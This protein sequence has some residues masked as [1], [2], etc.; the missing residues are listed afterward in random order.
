MAAAE[1]EAGNGGKKGGAIGMIV[2][3]VGVTVLAAG[4]GG[5]VAWLLL[6]VVKRAIEAQAKDEA[7]A[8]TEALAYSEKSTVRRL[9]P[10]ITNLAAPSGAWIRLEA[11]IVFEGEPP[12]EQDALA[13]RISED[14]LAF[15]RTVRLDQI[16][17]P[18]GFLHLREDLSERAVIRSDGLVR[19]VVIGGLVVE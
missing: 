17:G 11:S 19:E 16:E 15:L 3:I 1:G 9:D 8:K 2:A 12:S 18:S 4:A 6:D 10:I 13:A 14:I 7:K 5:G